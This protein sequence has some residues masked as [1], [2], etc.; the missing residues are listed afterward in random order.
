MLWESGELPL[1]E[2]ETLHPYEDVPRLAALGGQMA[3]IA[4]TATPD[5]EAGWAELRGRLS[6]R[7]R[8]HGRGGALSS[9]R[10]QWRARRLLVAAVSAALV[11]GTSIAYAAGVEPV[12]REV[13]EIIERVSNLFTGHNA[14]DADADPA[15]TGTDQNPTRDDTGG[16]G[17]GQDSSGGQNGSGTDQG[18]SGQG[19]QGGSGHGGQ[20]GS[21]TDQ[22][23]SGQGDQGN[24][25]RDQGGSGQGDQGNSGTD[26]GGSGR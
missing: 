11:G 18:G 24:S 3:A 17:T 7:E 13:N 12:R 1:A 2:L 14:G 19:G 25:G 6:E 16:S 23:G 21:G 4:E 15:N 9:A 20:G 26:Q 22:G 8:E 5:P 10:L